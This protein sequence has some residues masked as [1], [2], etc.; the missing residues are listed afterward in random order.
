MRFGEADI[1]REVDEHRMTVDA[2]RLLIGLPSGLP[3][4]N[5]QAPQRDPSMEERVRHEQSEHYRD[6]MN[7]S[8]R[9]SLLR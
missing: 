1:L 2:A 9:G 4:L 5:W 6:A 3:P 7:D 8:G